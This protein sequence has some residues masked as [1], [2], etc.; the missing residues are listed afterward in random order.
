[1]VVAYVTVHPTLDRADA[2]TRIYALVL[3]CA[4]SDE[5]EDVLVR[6]S[7][8][9]GAGFGVFPSTAGG[10][11]WSDLRHP[12]LLPYL[13]MESVVT[14][15]HSLKLLVCVLRGEFFLKNLR[16]PGAVKL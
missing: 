13:G 10:L 3:P 15:H 8:V 1:M 11:N 4:S 14:D 16:D 2:G 9:S 12:V 7:N 6:N 5:W